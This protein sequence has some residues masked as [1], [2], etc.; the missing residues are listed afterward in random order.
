MRTAQRRNEPQVEV[1][2]VPDARPPRIAPVDHPLEAD[3]EARAEAALSVQ[4]DWEPDLRGVTVHDDATARRSADAIGAVAYTRGSDVYLGSEYEAGTPA[5][6]HVLAH[7][8]AHVEQRNGDDEIHRYPSTAFSAPVDWLKTTESVIRPGEG[9]SGGVYILKS[10]DDGGE[11]TSAVAKP[12]SGKNAADEDESGAQLVFADKAL[13]MIGVNAPTSRV[14]KK[15]KEFNHLLQLVAP[16]QPPKPAPGEEGHQSWWPIRA[17]QEFVV[18]GQVP[19]GTS[20]MS[21]SKK[22]GSDPDALDALGKVLFDTE[23]LHQLGGLCAGDLFVGNGDRLMGS[24]G[25]LG[26]VMVSIVE[27]KASPWAIDTTASLPKQFDP[28]TVLKSGSTS[29]TLGSIMNGTAV[30]FRNGIN[31]RLEAMMDNVIDQVGKATP[32]PQPNQMSPKDSLEL[33]WLG[34]KAMCVEA[35][36]AGF[37]GMLQKISAMVSQKEGREKVK[38]L[39]DEFSGEKGSESLDFE[40][41]MVNANY[42]SMKSEGVDDEKALENTAGK[43]AIKALPSVNTTAWFPPVDA[44][45]HRS[46]HAPTGSV[47]STDLV[48]PDKVPNP[49]YWVRSSSRGLPDPSWA[50][51]FTAFV[52]DMKQ[53]ANNDLGGNKKKSLL[54]PKERPHNRAAAVGVF[55][56]A[57]YLG[58]GHARTVGATQQ[59]DK[60][61][62]VL[63][64]AVAA[65]PTPAEASALLP[66]ART[67]SVFRKIVEDQLQGYDRKIVPQVAALKKPRA[68]GESAKKR[69]TLV[70]KL[71]EQNQVSSFVQ[72]RLDENA[73]KK[74]DDIVRSLERLA[75]ATVPSETS[76]AKPRKQL[77]GSRGKK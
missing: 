69:D 37:D 57:N 75:T 36:L 51:Q 67:F 71:T 17:T 35:F 43:A 1:E 64:L 31:K 39:T 50:S 22:A 8:L 14:V 53:K 74:L 16:K 25:N 52:E 62:T 30:N 46:V 34:A 26:N 10:K 28:Q 41:M 44:L 49:Q 40:S 15:G 72:K 61:G 5:G 66:F 76:K 23:F 45:D 21:M 19:N 65:R 63:P 32:L 18:M 11:V 48:L 55:G 4:R 58:A 59:L 3:A 70:Q 13:R 77:I 7:E 54:N 24:A 6:D 29:W 73:P 47:L 27:G 9:V 20:L 12:L 38:S 2:R 68:T 60:Y 56:D 42:L 33:Q